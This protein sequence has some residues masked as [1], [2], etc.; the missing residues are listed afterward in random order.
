[1]NCGCV[2]N[3]PSH[4]VSLIVLL[5][6]GIC[7]VLVVSYISGVRQCLLV[8]WPLIGLLYRC[9]MVDDYGTLLE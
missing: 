4:L 3:Q 8:L 5:C 7:V 2:I 9:M 6:I 1:M